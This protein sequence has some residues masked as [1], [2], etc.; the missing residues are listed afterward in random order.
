MTILEMAA[1]VPAPAEGD[2]YHSLREGRAKMPGHLTPDFQELLKA[3][4]HPDA[5]S[6][7][8]AREI[9]RSPLLRDLLRDGSI[10]CL[11]SQPPLHRLDQKTRFD[12]MDARAPPEAVASVQGRAVKAEREA[13]HLR[14][15]LK[16]ARLEAEVLR[17]RVKLLEEC[18]AKDQKTD[19]PV[20]FCDALQPA[21]TPCASASSVGASLLSLGEN[22][23]PPAQPHKRGPSNPAAGAPARG[24]LGSIGDGFVVPIVRKE[25]TASAEGVAYVDS[26]MS[27]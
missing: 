18:A 22:L 11:R 4:L 2:E 16:A 17:K 7:P 13:A 25:T 12:L 15:Q 3:L 1:G 23:F 14:A 21:S 10:A 26:A 5:A 24:D 9:V 19:V 27:T 20:A 6:R 8:E